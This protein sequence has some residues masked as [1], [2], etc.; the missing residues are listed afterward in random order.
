MEH[1][2]YSVFEIVKNKGK[3]ANEEFRRDAVPSR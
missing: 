1:F 3:I 2:I